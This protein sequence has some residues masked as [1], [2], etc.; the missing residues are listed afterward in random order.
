MQR[1]ARDE[2]PNTHE[3]PWTEVDRWNEIF[4]DRAQGKRKGEVLH[5]LDQALLSF[6]EA[7]ALLPE[8]RFADGK[9]AAKMVDLA[10]VAHFKEH[11]D[12][13]RA[14]RARQ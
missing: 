3:I 1:M 11:A 14:W 9:T 6:K 10:G 8:A 7:A 5:E 4:A 2:E 12:M 13:I